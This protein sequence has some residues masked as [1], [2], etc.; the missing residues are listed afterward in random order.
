[1]SAATD[2]TRRTDRWGRRFYVADEPGSPETLRVLVQVTGAEPREVGWLERWPAGGG[3]RAYWSWVCT[4]DGQ[5][6]ESRR[7]FEV[8]P[9]SGSTPIA[10]AFHA[11]VA[12]SGSSGRS[13]GDRRR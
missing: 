1:M 2:A 13:I 5:R 11:L 3:R 9:L 6:T 10:D 7:R 4:L 8:N 12:S